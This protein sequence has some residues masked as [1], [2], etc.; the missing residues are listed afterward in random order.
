[1]IVSDTAG[2]RETNELVEK[3]G[4]RRAKSSIEN[5]DLI[6]FVIDGFKMEK[7]FQESEEEKE[8]DYEESVT[9]LQQ[10][11]DSYYAQLGLARNV[12]NDKR[13]M[14]V[15]NKA[16]LMSEKIVNHLE[17]LNILAISCTNDFKIKNL[18]DEITVHLQELCGNPSAECVHLSQHRHRHHMTECLTHIH[19]FLD[20]Y[21]NSAEIDLAIAVQNI[22]S[23]IR[24]IGFVT[25]EVKT[26]E[27]L[28]IIFQ[29]F[30]IG[31]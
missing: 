1:V 6:V 22:R 2:I 11:L 5:A 19:H 17:K 21:D 25:G 31:K 27:I 8:R 30:C 18:V 28:D 20:E 7:Y 15:V 24:S 29:Q 14:I 23:S 13:C 4:I 16:D 3:E 12:L 26:D 9:S 10:Y